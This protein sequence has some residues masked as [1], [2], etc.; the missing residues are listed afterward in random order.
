MR[1]S[2]RADSPW[3]G[4]MR[5]LAL[6]LACAGWAGAALVDPDP[7]SLLKSKKIL[8]LD[9]G[10]GSH[11]QAAAAGTANLKAMQTLL[12]LNITFSANWQTPIFAGYDIVVFNYFFETQKMTPAGQKNFQ[13]WLATGHKGYVG[14][15]TS[16]ANEENEWN[17][18]RDNVTSMLYKLHTNPEQTGTIHANRDAKI[19]AHPIMKGIDTVFTNS[20]EWYDFAFGATWADA[21]VTFFLDE[22]TLVQ[23]KPVR[24]MNPHP[25]SWFREDPATK[26]RFYYSAF[27]HT[28][29]GAASDFFRNTILRALEYVSGYEPGY[30]DG[31]TP[32]NMDGHSIRTFAAFSFVSG[33]RELQVNV[34]GPYALEVYSMGGRELER[35]SGRGRA[36]LL[37]ASFAKP[38]LYI[39]KFRAEG[40]T[41]VQRA[42]IY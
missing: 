10:S 39:V 30:E 13:D 28:Q 17:W 38:G 34:P 8:V 36:T 32:I 4:W 7:H 6:W 41:I 21:R 9:G 26:D 11:P 24:P 3:H 37:P 12:G 23:Y 35:L 25:M 29:Q 16:G 27:I 31:T 19:L 5:M 33:S 20:D 40:R 42:M 2:R 1:S 14:Y 15:H 18:Y 22:G